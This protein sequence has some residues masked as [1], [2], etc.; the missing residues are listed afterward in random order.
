MSVSAPPAYAFLPLSSRNVFARSDAPLT[1]AS[2]KDL[3]TVAASSSA[4]GW[5]GSAGAVLNQRPPPRRKPNEGP[6]GAQSGG[7]DVQIGRA[8]G[9]GR[10]AISVG[11][12]SLKQKKK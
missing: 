10:G 6:F 1:R 8:S 11:A 4:V 7:W 12:V 3:T 2:M 5:G 9:R